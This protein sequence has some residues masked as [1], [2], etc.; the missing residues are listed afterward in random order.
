MNEDSFGPSEVGERELLLS[1]YRPC[2]LNMESVQKNQ[3]TTANGIVLEA[4]KGATFK[5][6]IDGDREI[7][8]HISGKMRMNHIK[9]LPGD[10][11][12][13]ELTPY[14]ERRGRITRRL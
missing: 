5:V 4:L 12:V 14:D 6:K 2:K 8:G 9:I 11:V 3:T 7:L 13:V 10:R 1:Y